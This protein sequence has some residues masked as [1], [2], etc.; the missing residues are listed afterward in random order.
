V[1]ARTG[2]AKHLEDDDSA[3][4][5]ARLLNLEELVGSIAEYEEEIANA[6][7]LA[8]LSGYLERVTL[9]SAVDT[10]EDAP[11]VAMMTV[12]A[13]KGLEFHAV[14]LTGMEEEMF[15]FRG[16]DPAHAD[17]LEEERRLAYVAITRARQRLAI[18]HASTRMIFG[19]TRYGMP[20]RFIGDLPRS[21]IEMIATP[22]ATEI[23]PRSSLSPAASS[24]R[25]SGPWVHPVERAPSFGRNR[26]EPQTRVASG[27]AP[28]WATPRAAMKLDPARAPG[29]RFVERD[30]SDDVGEG[31]LRVGGRVMHTKYGAGLVRS[32][33]DG[34]DP[35]V[36]VRFAGWGEKRIKAGFL[37]PS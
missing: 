10:L 20:S 16:L 11:K 31:G 22:M 17:E 4:S 29:E 21:A 25:A 6:G 23:A 28:A 12:H 33:D 18:T 30:D 32:I 34:D 13:A 37:R 15:P 1:L 3:A 14:F 36:T 24:E 8:T 5:D 26:T 7:E 2:Y 27:E 35:I 19:K 9:E